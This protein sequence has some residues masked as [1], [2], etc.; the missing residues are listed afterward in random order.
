MHALFWLVD[1][2]LSLF[3]WA[4]IIGAV[5][6]LLI[7][8]NV[9]DT[10]NRAVWAIADFF[11]RLTEPALRPIRRFIPNLGGID[12]SPVILILL[13]QAGRILLAEIQFGLLGSS[14]GR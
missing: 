6:S 8:F 10:R 3:V 13:L 12:I 14:F 5:I 2:A 1:T 7:A 9:L 4:L 11:H